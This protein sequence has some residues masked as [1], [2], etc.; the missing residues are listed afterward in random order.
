Y[1]DNFDGALF[2][3]DYGRN[4]IWT[5]F[6]GVGGA[7]DPSTRAAFVSGADGP[8]DLKIGPNGDLFYVDFNF[9]SL[10][11]IQYFPGNAPPLAV[12]SATPNGGGL[13]LQVQ[14]DASASSDPD[15]GDVLSY[16][17]DLDG[18]GELDDS[19]AVA[20]MHV[21]TE[22]ATITVS[23]RVS[24]QDGL[25]S[26]ATTIVTPGNTPPTAV[27]DSPI[28]G[29]SWQVSDMIA[30]SGSATD[31]EDGTLPG[32]A[33]SWAIILHHCPQECHQHPLQEITGVASTTFVAPDHDYPAFLEI[34]LTATD[35]N[36]VSHTVAREIHP[37]TVQL[38]FAS[39]PSGLTLSVGGFS[40]T[41]PFSREVIVGSS[42]EIGASSRQAL[43]A[44]TYAFSSWSDGGDRN[45]TVVAGSTPV[46]FTANYAQ[47]VLPPCSGDFCDITPLGNI[48]AA[49]QSPGGGGSTDIEVIRDGD[50]PP[51][52]NEESLRQ[53]DTYDGPETANEDWIGYE[54]T[55]S[56]DFTRVVF[57]EGRHFEDGGWFAT[58]TVQVRQ[59]GVWQNITGLAI[60][61]P[62]PGI[63]NGVTYETYTLDFPSVTGD[64]I[65]IYGVP[66]GASTFISVGE[67]EVFTADEA[68]GGTPTPTITA[69]PTPTLPAGCGNL[70][71]EAGEQC[72]DGNLLPGDC[73]DAN[74]QLEDPPACEVTQLGTIVA[75]F[76]VAGGGGNADLEV[77]RDGDKPEVGSE[78]SQRQYD[79]YHGEDPGSADWMGYQY[80]GTYPFTRVVFQEGRHFEDGGWF[81]SLGLQV[82]Q[83]GTWQDVTGL[84]STPPYPAS[85]DGTP[86][87]TYVLDFPPVAGNGVRL[88]GIAGGASGFTSV[89][90]LEVFV[91]S[92]DVPP[93]A[94]ATVSGPTATATAT[95]T[96]TP[97]PSATATGTATPTAGSPTPTTEGSVQIRMNKGTSLAADANFDGRACVSASVVAGG[98]AI[99]AVTTVIEFDP[100]RFALENCS[101]DPGISTPEIGKTL[102]REN[103]S[104]GVE[105]ITVSGGPTAI[106]SSED[107]YVCTFRT[108]LGTTPGSYPLEFSA[109]A[110]DGAGGEVAVI[111]LANEIEVTTCNGDCDGSGSV[112]IGEVVRAINHFGGVP[113]CNP[114]APTTS[115]PTCD[116]D[117][118]GAVSIG[119]VVNS[120]NRFGG[121]CP[122]P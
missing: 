112:V 25:S 114:A 60:S 11:R 111:A 27:M 96:I 34:R 69:T 21:Y 103:L 89:A 16:A 102:S 116:R 57:Q 75:A 85:N 35:S 67:L 52:G 47:I 119:E 88:H 59:G 48:I 26:I 83:N 78:D 55:E 76:P 90:E 115:C 10:R 44:E 50:K 95:R 113:L 24:D 107:L 93:T 120:L 72:D 29:A 86:F 14:F 37:E 70:A 23:L 81:A 3:G 64:A 62:Y 118:N 74:C 8:V 9:G 6:P 20:P 45:H 38:G 100:T 7:P 98:P 15:Q 65:R 63:N 32:A 4:C 49:V 22:A 33:L 42:A 105:R 92:G 40:A 73:C 91:G 36:G 53:Y 2:F 87:N 104:S 117:N 54:F 31:P 41:A 5:M 77:I 122:A 99:A 79:T 17:W 106:P 71:L 58:L 19:T 68:S 51:V 1:P 97:T 82:L 110:E 101:I 28:A 80:P 109:T 121:G 108:L 30:L 18:D 39:V 61:P 46:T 12:L 66:G 56:H 94:T 13:P 84:V 43:G